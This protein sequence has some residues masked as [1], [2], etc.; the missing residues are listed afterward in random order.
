MKSS[1]LEKKGRS[2]YIRKYTNTNP[3]LESGDVLGK[4][5]QMSP[6]PTMLIKDHMVSNRAAHI[7]TPK[8]IT[9]LQLNPDTLKQQQDAHMLQKEKSILKEQQRH[10]AVK[11]EGLK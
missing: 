5:Q 8:E 11:C 3:L 10:P 9:P 7:F 4:R 6:P 1:S 2:V